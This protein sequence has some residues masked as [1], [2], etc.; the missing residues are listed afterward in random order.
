MQMVY[1][2]PDGLLNVLDSVGRVDSVVLVIL[3]VLLVVVVVVF[4]VVVGIVVDDVFVIGS[5]SGSVTFSFF[6]KILL[7][8]GVR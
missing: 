2:L 4:I 7:S 8:K 5:V 3:I 6:V 1:V